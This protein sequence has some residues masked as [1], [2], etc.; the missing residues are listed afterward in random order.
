MKAC[1]FRRRALLLLFFSLLIH[2]LVSLETT[3]TCEDEDEC[4]GTDLIDDADEDEVTDDDDILSKPDNYVLDEVNEDE[5]SD[6]QEVDSD[7]IK[8]PKGANAQ[9]RPR[10]S[11]LNCVDRYSECDTFR[12][13]DECTKNPG[14]MI[15]NCPQSCNAC[16]LRDPKVRC[17]HKFLNVSHDPIFRMGDLE[18]MFQRIVREYSSKYKVNVLSKSPWVV[19]FDDFM[20]DEECDALINTV[21][22]WERSTDTGETNALGETGRVLSSGRTSSNAWCRTECEQDPDVQNV[23]ARIEEVTTVPKNHYESFQILKYTVGQK[24]STHH[25]SDESDNNIPCGPRI[26]TFFLYLSD[27]EEGGETSFPTLGISVKPKKGRALLWPSVLNHWPNRVD[28]R[29]THEAKPVIKG[30]KFAANAWIHLF[31]F[32]Q[33]NLWGCTGTFDEL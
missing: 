3:D 21:D 33:A 18:A 14:W 23:M 30:K 26:L 27:V 28:G 25:D 16:H 24:Y 8:I 17:T 9:G 12:K 5:D 2:S 32:Q 15:M 13:N 10:E 6:A 1:G 20:T 29:T 19:T 31:D 11:S 7:D 4:L 22:E